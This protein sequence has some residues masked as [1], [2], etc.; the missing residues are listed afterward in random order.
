MTVT[1]MLRFAS[2]KS[3][4]NGFFELNQQF[5]NIGMKRKMTC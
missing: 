4:I 5:I 2:Q 1:L 3:K